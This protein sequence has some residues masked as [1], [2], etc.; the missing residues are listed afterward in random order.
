MT[1]GAP[2]RNGEIKTANTQTLLETLFLA[3]DINMWNQ[4]KLRWAK[5]YLHSFG[6]FHFSSLT[7]L[8]GLCV[9][10]YWIAYGGFDPANCVHTFLLLSLAGVYCF[11]NLDAYRKCSVWCTRTNIY[12]PGQKP[13]SDVELTVADYNSSHG[14]SIMYIMAQLPW[15]R[16][17]S[18]VMLRTY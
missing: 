3:K 9:D 13:L 2:S 10:R 8:I 14:F 18:H 5:R 15:V 4:K 7:F 12:R 16:Q 17:Q 6:P 11:T 1:Q